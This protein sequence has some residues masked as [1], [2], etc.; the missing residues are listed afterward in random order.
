MVKLRVTMNYVNRDLVY[1]AGQ[2]IEV[3]EEQARYLM[4]DAPEVFE[5]HKEVTAPPKDKMIKSPARSKTARRTK[6]AES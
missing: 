3:S 1:K 6:D 2:I 4:A 5:I